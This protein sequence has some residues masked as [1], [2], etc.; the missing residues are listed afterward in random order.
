MSE[1]PLL[2][3]TPPRS[4]GGGVQLGLEVPLYRGTS[5]LAPGEKYASGGRWGRSP[6]VQPYQ[7]HPA[8]EVGTY[9]GTSLI[10]NSAPQGPYSR[11]I[12]RDL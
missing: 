6:R 8:V 7:S 2:P 3:A 10:R 5:G 12:P 1:V 9:R 11:N 4:C